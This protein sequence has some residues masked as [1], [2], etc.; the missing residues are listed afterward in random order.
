MKRLVLG[1]VFTAISTFVIL[2][3]FA[4]DQAK[5][6]PDWWFNEVVDAGFVGQYATI[7]PKKEVLIVDS[8]PAR[9]YNKGHIVPATNISNSQFDKMTHLLPQN[10]SNLL[11]FYCGGLKCPLSHKSAVKAEALGYTN[12]KVYAAGYP[13]WVKN[14]SLPPGVSAEHVKKLIDKNKGASI[15]DARPARKF[16]KGHLPGAINIPA[17][18]FDEMV[19]TLPA[20]KNTPLIFYCGGYKC[21]LSPKSAAKAIALGYTKVRLFQAG[22]PA[23]K[24]AYGETVEMTAKAK[25]AAALKIEEGEDEGTISIA[26]FNRLA[27]DNP[28]DFHWY[29]VRDPEEVESDGTFGK[30]VIMTV[31]EVEDNVD[32]LPTDKPIVFFCSTGARSGE[33]YDL[34]RMKREDLKIYFL[35][36]NV[37]FNPDGSVPKATPPD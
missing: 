5:G 21:P 6:K 27:T 19:D 17:R 3:V 12:V 32:K 30:A 16:K 1:I 2:P 35:D 36:A 22:F 11:I 29:D 25:P 31:D 15:V 8:R 23:W 7:P 33:A 37:A 34:V 26:S 10:K 9:K 18:Q 20:D 24:K 14:G 4:A 28:D 13:D